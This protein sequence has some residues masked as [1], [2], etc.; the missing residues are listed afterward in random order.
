MGLNRNVVTRQPRPR[1]RFAPP[2]VFIYDAEEEDLSPSSTTTPSYRS[3]FPICLSS[4]FPD[5]HPFGLPNPQTTAPEASLRSAV[6]AF[7]QVFGGLPGLDEE[8]PVASGDER[9]ERFVRVVR[10]LRCEAE[11]GEVAK[12]EGV[13]VEWWMRGCR[14]GSSVSGVRRRR[15]GGG[16][17]VGGGGFGIGKVGD[18][19]FGIGDGLWSEA[20][21]DV[22]EEDS[23]DCDVECH[24]DVPG[25]LEDLLRRDYTH[26]IA[27]VLNDIL[28]RTRF[29]RRFEFELVDVT[30]KQSPTETD[31]AV[32]VDWEGA[33]SS[34]TSS[35]QS[36]SPIPASPSP[37]DDE[38]DPLSDTASDSDL[39][40]RDDPFYDVHSSSSS[41]SPTSTPTP[42]SSPPPLLTPPTSLTLSI[43]PSSNARKV[44]LVQ[45]LMQ[46]LGHPSAF[47]VFPSVTSCEKSREY[48]FTKLPNTLLVMF[49]RDELPTPFTQPPTI[50]N[51]PIP[52]LPS[53][54]HQPAKTF[55]TIHLPLELDLS[56]L[57]SHTP[58][59]SPS[60]SPSSKPP[61]TF[62]TLHGFITHL[63]PPTPTPSQPSKAPKFIAYTRVSNGPTWYRCEDENVRE[64]E[65]GVGGVESL[66]VVC[67]VY[68]VV[69]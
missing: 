58:S 43:P 62:Y 18:N 38:S 21:V 1:V 7:L 47:D 64:V 68:R 34:S 19:G 53:S 61:K 30:P 55:P 14:M 37:S 66:G 46:K 39:E 67:G 69:S 65:L 56:S 44:T 45:L 22:I 9:V 48:R 49:R 36:P 52:I 3:P 23:N 25:M 60:C 63:P 57:L 8:L 54:H 42:T 6:N 24:S 5:R 11:V 10:G 15:V 59:P 40:E 12:E 33:G 13:D 4:A 16:R 29:G 35:S 26:A 27:P 32:D 41:S 31:S 28:P 50:N 51:T 2:K 20:G 17:A